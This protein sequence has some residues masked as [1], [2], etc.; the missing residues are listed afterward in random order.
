MVSTMDRHRRIEGRLLTEELGV[1]WTSSDFT[2]AGEWIG[3]DKRLDSPEGCPSS[4]VSSSMRSRSMASSSSPLIR[5]ENFLN[6]REP[7]D[8][9]GVLVTG[10]DVA[11]VNI[12]CWRLDTTVDDLP[13]EVDARGLSGERSRLSFLGAQLIGTLKLH[14]E[15]ITLLESQQHINQQ[16]LISGLSK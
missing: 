1:T 4:C 16:I 15:L 7:S 10:V 11:A 9:L 13:W 6:G 12:D 5:D 2:F 3:A 8:R 14:T